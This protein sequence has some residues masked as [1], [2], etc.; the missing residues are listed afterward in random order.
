MAHQA[1]E[2]LRA[3]KEQQGIEQPFAF[4]QAPLIVHRLFLKKPER[5]EAVGVGVWRALLLW[6]LVERALR[7]QGETTGS[8]WTGWDKQETQTPTA[9]MMMIK[10]A[11]VTVLKGGDQRQRAPPWQRSNSHTSRRCGFLPTPS[12]RPR[13]E[14]ATWRARVGAHRA[15]AH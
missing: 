6:R 11:A 5:I 3:Y 1:R 4:L 10:F 14:N 2:V 7:V 9:V 13:G 15:L 12:Q 8:T